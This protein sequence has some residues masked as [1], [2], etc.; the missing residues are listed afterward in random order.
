MTQNNRSEKANEDH[1]I[2]NMT[3]TNLGGALRYTMGMKT[4]EYTLKVL[5]IC[6]NRSERFLRTENSSYNL[7]TCSAGFPKPDYLGE[8]VVTNISNEK[9]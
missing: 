8:A 2:G 3:V 9:A 4:T 6:D 5:H 7:K 1:R